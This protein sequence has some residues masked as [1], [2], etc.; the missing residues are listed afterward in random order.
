MAG[1]N[2][3]EAFSAFVEPL[4]NALAC[5]TQVRYEVTEGGRKTVGGPHGLYLT[6]MKNNEGYAALGGEAHLEFRA[7]MFYEIITDDRP[8]YGPYRVKT[9]SYDYSLRTADSRGVIDYHWHPTGKSHEVRPHIHIG[10]AQLADDAVLAKKDHI[11]CGRITLEEVIRN[12]IG[13]GTK[14]LVAKWDDRLV[15]SEGPHKLF[16]SWS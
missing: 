4:T 12:A 14:T 1:R 13:L 5:I 6:G 3:T 11:L 8:D 10:T 16:R 2:P 7:R 9:L 15:E